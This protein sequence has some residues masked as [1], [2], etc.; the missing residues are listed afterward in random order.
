M[1]PYQCLMKYTVN[2]VVVGTIYNIN[3]PIPVSAGS[4]A[5]I[6]CRSLPGIAGSNPAGGKDVCLLWVF[7][8]SGRGLC[9]GLIIRPEESYRVWCVSECD[10][11]A[12]IMGG[13]WPTGGA[14][15]PL[16]D[17]IITKWPRVNDVVGQVYGD[18]KL[19]KRNARN[20]GVHVDK[21]RRKWEKEGKKT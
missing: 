6:C 21:Y 14:A 17:K 11:E 12:S 9:I 13:P 1:R 19:Y 16:G 4:E 8:L 15:A 5:W 2:N 10:R 18:I 3:V 7:V 20:E